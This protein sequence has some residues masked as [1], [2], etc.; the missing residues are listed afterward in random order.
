MPGPNTFTTKYG[1]TITRYPM[2]RAAARVCFE[3]GC[4]VFFGKGPKAAMIDLD[5]IR[6]N[7]G[8]ATFDAMIAHAERNGLST[9]QLWFQKGS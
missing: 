4:A 3:A 7:H 9:K 6:E 8:I 5:W 2:D 1:G